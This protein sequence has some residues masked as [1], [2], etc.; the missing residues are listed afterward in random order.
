MVLAQTASRPAIDDARKVLSDIFG[1]DHFRG[2]QEQVISH[3][4]AGGDALVYLLRK[5]IFN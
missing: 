1:Y 5:L 3:V 2:M 4:L